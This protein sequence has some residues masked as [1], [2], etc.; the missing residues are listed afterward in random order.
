MNEPTSPV[1]GREE[2]PSGRERLG[3]AGRI[4]A[5]FLGKRELS[6]LTIIVVAAWGTLSFILTPKQYNPDIVAPAFVIVTDFPNASASEVYE[7]ITRPMEDRVSE[8]P[9]IDEISSES[10]PGGRSMVMV[11]FLVGYDREEAKI[12]L[13]QKLRDHITQKPAGAMDPIVQSVDPDDVPIIDIGLTS[14]TLSETSLRRLAADVA[15]ELKREDGVSRV[16]VIGGRVNRLLVEPRASEL[17]ARGISLGEIAGII[18]GSNGIGLVE[19]VD[20]EDRTPS[21]TVSGNL[22]GTEDLGNLVIRQEGSA[23]TRLSDIADISY[24]PG[25]ITDSV[26]LSEHEGSDSPVVHI[27]LSKLRGTNATTVS[28]GVLSRL[29]SLKGT[30]IP[31]DVSAH[32][33]RDEGAIAGE[34]IGKLTFD[35]TKSVIVVAVLLMMFLGFRN[36]MV[37]AVSIPLVLL[38]VFGM[39]LF[40][41]QTVNR[42]TLFALILAL[43]LLVDDA[44]VV[45][46]NVARYFRLYPG[47]NRI[48]LIVKAVD[49]VGGALALSTLTMAISFI[50]MAFVTGMMGPYMAPIPFFVPASLFASLLFSVTVNPFLA[51]VF[52]PKDTGKDHAHE[53]FF[54]RQFER[55]D[56]RYG[57]LLSSLLATRKRRLGTILGTAAIF[58]VSVI[59]PFSPAVPFR[60]LPKADRQQFYV[61]LDMPTSTSVDVTRDIARET[62]SVA[63]DISEVESVESFV[64]EAPV[65]DFNGLFK[66]SA[67]RVSGNQATLRV[68]L[69]ES[70]DRD[71]MSEEIASDFRKRAERLSQE[72]PD[73]SVRIMEDPPG[74]PVM[75]TFY[76][77]VKGDDERVR[78]DMARDIEDEVRNISGTT[79]IDRSTPER[80]LG[81][82]Y[83]IRTEKAGLLG[84]SPSDIAATL[85]I[86]LSG[87]QVGLYH[88]S[89]APGVRQ[90][91]QEYVFL[92]LA[93]ESR[94]EENDLSGISIP[95]RTTGTQVPLTELLEKTDRATDLPILSDNR[96]PT[97]AVSAE[98]EGR[99]VVY[100]VIDLFPKL[101]S[102]RLPDGNGKLVSWSLLGAE[103]EDQTTGKRYAVELGGEWKLTLEVF[104]DLGIAMGV[105]IFLIYFVLAAKTESLFVPLLIMVS[106]PLGLIGV[107]PGFALLHAIKGTYFNATSMIGVISL[108][109]LSVKNSVIFLEYLEPLRKA[110]K[111][112]KEALVETGRVR[113]LPITLTS[114]TAILGSLTIITDP[115]W[116]GLAWAIIFG[117][118][119]STFLTLV[120]FPLVYHVFERKHWDA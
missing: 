16:E 71:R 32:V 11:K 7:L 56:R 120:I 67:T 21:L 10:H 111:P 64:G 97:V 35:L 23:V 61:Y 107:F 6:I 72:H 102:Y 88:E 94:D 82:S 76:L 58:A 18:G 42:I 99:S 103:Y 38:A 62:E 19:P 105:A 34:E 14:E 43:G 81:Y 75:A 50:P 93:R 115:V 44:I 96:Q 39:G 36:A 8:L 27:A 59:L 49:E 26:D 87:A 4:T 113:L 37:A 110:G 60:M 65:S 117:L 24:G 1:S 29:E 73:M 68:N 40:A 92:R 109:G 47:E 17:S 85:H 22:R 77:K 119:A 79:D 20:G 112:L 55:L 114:L 104:R 100:A 15:D 46:E 3:L 118:S 9:G 90:S 45:I 95:S 54:L 52:T 108:A 69:S 66:G 57:K 101:L 28:E 30:T 41:G 74:P 84:V 13:N 89:L 91:E 25:E 51:L 83:R 31:S 12:A 86:A 63:L 48:R 80:V 106:I 98:M 116:E 70:E 53:G 5:L 78:E 33:L 2:A